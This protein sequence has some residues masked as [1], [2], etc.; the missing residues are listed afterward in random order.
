MSEEKSEVV[1]KAW[2]STYGLI[3]AERI[4]GKYKIKLAQNDLITAIKSPTSFY[5][6]LLEIPLKHVLNGIVLQQANDYHVYTQKLFIDYLLSGEHSKEEDTQGATTREDLENERLQLL[7]LGE[8]YNKTEEAHHNLIAS[9]QS[10]LIKITR[11]FNA[12]MEKA[13]TEISETLKKIGSSDVKNKVPEAINH[14]LTFCNLH[15]QQLQSTPF[16]FIERMNDLLKIQLNKEVKEKI[17][18]QLAEVFDIV[19]N[20]DVNVSSF[21]EGAEEMSI[22]ANSFRDRFYDSIL[23][24]MELI[25]ILPEYKLDLQ[26]DMIN[27]ESLHFD[28]S[29]GAL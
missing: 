25:K 5:H 21:V 12:V 13:I 8:E 4:L 29:I 7:L 9:S 23:R 10:S 3:T 22:Q 24:V 16:P 1:S 2:F 14:A 6:K 28:K 20:F 27:R 15:D 26:Q 19:T 11:E 17:M 18:D